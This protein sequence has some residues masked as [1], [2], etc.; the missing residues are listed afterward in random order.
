MTSATSFFNMVRRVDPY[1]HASIDKGMTVMGLRRTNMFDRR[2]E[3]ALVTWTPWRGSLAEKLGKGHAAGGGSWLVMENGYVTPVDGRKVYTV[4]REGY[5]GRGD[6]GSD[7]RERFAALGHE[8]KPWR[9]TGSHILV[10]GQM[11]HRDTT[12]SMPVK[13]LESI[14]TELRHRTDRP[15]LIHPKP[16]SKDPYT[17]GDGVRIDRAP[18]PQL[19]ADCWALV[20]WSSKAA[21]LALIHGVPVFVIGPYSIARRMAMHSID[22]IESPYYP[23]DREDFLE[24]VADSQW[25]VAELESGE[26][27][28]RLLQ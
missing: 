2:P 19:L 5:N 7:N 10:V 20:T 23:E 26:P 27:F 17:T 18:I 22:S 16:G 21:M 6:H 3:C 28:R 24:H 25:S 13:W 1:P 8:I 11:G 15:I 9:K 12:V 4:G 14:H